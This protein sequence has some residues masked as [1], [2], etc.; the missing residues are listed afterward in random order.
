MTEIN[1]NT[2]IQNKKVPEVIAFYTMQKTIGW[3]GMLLPFILWLFNAIINNSGILN[4]KDYFILPCICNYDPGVALKSTISHFY[5]TSVGVI[6][7][8]VLCAVALYLISYKGYSKEDKEWLTDNRVTN[9][10]GIMAFLV[11]L[12]PTATDYD[13]NDNLKV[14]IS[15]DIT[16]YIHIGSALVFFSALAIMCLVNFRRTSKHGVYKSIKETWLYTVCGITIIGCLIAIIIYK[17]FFANENNIQ[18]PIIYWFETVALI[19]FGISWLHK[20]KTDFLFVPKKL[21]LI[22]K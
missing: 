12:F 15:G 19:A 10:A 5:Y 2:N 6:F 4:N 18:L 11:A 20:G 21:G 22:K 14:F 3:L 7:T 8:G 13:I 16:G 17:K 1:Q 9:T